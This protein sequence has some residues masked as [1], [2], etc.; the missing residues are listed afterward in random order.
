MANR[1]TLPLEARIAIEQGRAE[2]FK[3]AA[4]RYDLLFSPIVDLSVL[5]A[6]L[7]M[8]DVPAQRMPAIAGI[9][10]GAFT[11]RFARLPRWPLE[12][13]ITSGVCGNYWRQRDSIHD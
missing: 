9:T 3:T 12:L 7:S 2:T 11:S 4:V 6:G 5:T 13:A 1:P 10:S 8:I